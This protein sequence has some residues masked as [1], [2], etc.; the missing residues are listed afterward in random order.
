MEKLLIHK[1][2]LGHI[3]IPGDTEDKRSGNLSSRK[4]RRQVFQ[5]NSRAPSVSVEASELSPYP[6]CYNLLEVG[7]HDRDDYNVGV[8]HNQVVCVGIYIQVA[9]NLYKYFLFPKS[10]NCQNRENMTIGERIKLLREQL[11]M[12]QQEFS[13]KIGISRSYLAELEK[14]KYEPPDRILRL[15]SHTFGVSYRWLKEGEGEMWESKEGEIPP[16][17]PLDKELFYKVMGFIVKAIKERKLVGVSDDELLELVKLLYKKYKPLK[18]KG[19][20]GKLWDGLE[21]DVVILGK[22]FEKR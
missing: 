1:A 12:K 8:R 17:A 7:S 6:V 9:Y 14:N 5:R 22:T 19:V 11:R 16:D 18:D 13:K 20:S 2:E 15:I 3:H 4:N 21:Q 10:T